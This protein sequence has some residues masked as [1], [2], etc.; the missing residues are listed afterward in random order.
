MLTRRATWIKPLISWSKIGSGATDFGK[1]AK[2][3]LAESD[4]L[5]FRDVRFGWLTVDGDRAAVRLNF[6]WATHKK[7]SGKFEVL[8][9]SWNVRLVRESGEWLWARQDNAHAALANAL[10]PLDT[11]EQRA[12]LLN[13]EKEL[14][15]PR[16]LDTIHGWSSSDAKSGNFS[17]A[18]HETE[19]AFEI[20]ARVDS[21]HEYGVCHIRRGYV[22]GQWKRHADALSDYRKALDYFRQTKEPYWQGVALQNIGLLLRLTRKFAESEEA[23]RE[24][25]S[26][27]RASKDAFTEAADLYGLGLVCKE[28][29]RPAEALGYLEASVNVRQA[30]GN[31]AG[32]LDSMNAIGD[33]HSEADRLPAALA[34]Y[35]RCVKIA[36][37]IEDLPWLAYAREKVANTLTTMGE[38]IEALPLCRRCGPGDR[39]ARR[40]EQYCQAEGQDR[41]PRNRKPG[42]GST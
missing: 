24:S 38:Y 22:F 19:I 16:L 29:H 14:V 21:P 10:L 6:I 32:E 1:F 25:L 8:P 33:L 23:Y 9:Y 12:A 11:P 42:H 28:L 36:E 2:A 20:A 37:E 40:I 26:L 17:A 18:M 27:A 31:R 39:A 7:K 4:Q 3:V 5:E 34:A 15:D 30:M 13:D 35:R 41:G